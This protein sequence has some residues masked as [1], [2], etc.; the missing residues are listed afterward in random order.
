MDDL[1]RQRFLLDVEDAERAAQ[2]FLSNVTG[3]DKLLVSDSF[4][5]FGGLSSAP[6]LTQSGVDEMPSA[7]KQIWI[8]CRLWAICKKIRSMGSPPPYAGFALAH[9]KNWLAHPSNKYKEAGA[10]GGSK[11]SAYSGDLNELISQAVKNT[12]RTDTKSIF[13][14]LIG[15][16]YKCI[17]QIEEENSKLLIYYTNANGKSLSEEIS[18]SALGKRLKLHRKK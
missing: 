9:Y 15:K 5:T 8:A 3:L 1:N 16:S 2:P 12:G 17:E 7:E 18:L 14:H 4:H 10:A 6:A 13:K 11:K